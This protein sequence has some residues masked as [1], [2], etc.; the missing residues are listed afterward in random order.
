MAFLWRFFSKIARSGSAGTAVHY[1]KHI[2][3]E[4]ILEQY[5][6]IYNLLIDG[7][8]I[9][10]VEIPPRR[11]R[12]EGHHERWSVNEYLNLRKAFGKDNSAKAP[13]GNRTGS[14][15]GSA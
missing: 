10:R 2:C 6:D 8:K 9:A 11:S 12:R 13:V 3:F 4:H 7:T 15:K 14:E 1:S 5:E